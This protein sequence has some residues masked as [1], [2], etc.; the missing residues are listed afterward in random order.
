[1]LEQRTTLRCRAALVLIVQEGRR[2][3][4]HIPRV[5]HVS[6]QATLAGELAEFLDHRQVLRNPPAGN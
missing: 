1:M 5:A 3:F 2:R 6:H 4:D